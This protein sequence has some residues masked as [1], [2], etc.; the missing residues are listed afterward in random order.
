MEPCGSPAPD[1]EAHVL[2][3]LGLR[4]YSVGGDREFPITL[5]FRPSEH[6]HSASD[7]ISHHSAVQLVPVHGQT[8]FPEN[9]N[10]KCAFF[11]V[12]E[13]MSPSHHVHLRL[14]DKWIRGVNVLGGFF[15]IN[16]CG[17]TEGVFQGVMVIYHGRD[18]EDNPNGLPVKGIVIQCA[19]ANV[20][21]TGLCLRQSF[22]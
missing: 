21:H 18:A 2:P 16:T 9:L 14:N 5:P 22:L 8:I 6:L 19:F 13:D 4:R 15:G 12:Y 17:M 20:W 11:I 7:T 1:L 10:G 3:R